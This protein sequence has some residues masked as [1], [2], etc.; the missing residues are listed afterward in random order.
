MVIKSK[1]IECLVDE[2][3]MYLESP[4]DSSVYADSRDG[5]ALS[6]RIETF[7]HNALL[8]RTVCITNMQVPRKK[9][10][11]GIFNGLIR[12]ICEMNKYGMIFMVSVVNSQLSQG[13]I[14]KKYFQLNNSF[15]RV[16]G[17]PL[18]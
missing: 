6:I 12:R 9:Q 18:A 14:E 11:M 4:D 1:N 15:Y 16:I 10:G 13:F 7:E 5:G 2:V 8:Y 17:A 3:V